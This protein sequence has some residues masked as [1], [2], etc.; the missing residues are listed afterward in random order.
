[1][2]INR[3]PHLA[4]APP[5]QPRVESI[6]SIVRASSMNKRSFLQSILLCYFSIEVVG[7][8]SKASKAT[9]KLT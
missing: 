5:N 4:K 2:P 6:P 7:K 9:G 3:G 1:M 8:L